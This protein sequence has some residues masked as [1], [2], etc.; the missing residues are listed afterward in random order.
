MRLLAQGHCILFPPPPF[1][2]R[3]KAAMIPPACDGGSY[4]L[5]RCSGGQVLSE[6]RFKSVVHDS[7]APSPS[8]PDSLGFVKSAV[9]GNGKL[10]KNGF[11]NAPIYLCSS[12][13]FVVKDTP[14]RPKSIPRARI[15]LMV[16]ASS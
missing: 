2:C 16:T 10:L 5:I 6:P 7:R 12:R 4:S 1:P 8:C 15:G 9:T 14:W 13:E 11:L 3:L